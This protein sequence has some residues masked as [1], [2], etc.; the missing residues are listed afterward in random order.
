MTDVNEEFVKENSEKITEDDVEDV[1]NKEEELKEKLKGVKRGFFRRFR[2]RLK[3]IF[4]LLTDYWGK[5][6]TYP[7]WT[8]ISSL[9]FA[10]LYF[11]APL[12]CIPDVLLLGYT[13]DL[14]VLT[15]IWKAVENDLKK[16]AVWKKLNLKDFFS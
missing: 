16:Y 7:P 5:K 12:D 6:Y 14:I 2:K 1:I 15:L 4:T 11:I 10:L 8:T 13:D 3:L 9:T